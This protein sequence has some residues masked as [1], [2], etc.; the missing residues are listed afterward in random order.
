MVGMRHR[1]GCDD[2]ELRPAASSRSHV[3]L[4]IEAGSR[5]LRT[6]RAASRARLCSRSSVKSRCARGCPLTALTARARTI[7]SRWRSLY[8]S[9]SPGRSACSWT[10]PPRRC[11]TPGA[12][13]Q[14][15]FFK[16]IAS[17]DRGHGGPIP[18]RAVPDRPGTSMP[19]GSS[20]ASAAGS[21]NATAMTATNAHRQARGAMDAGA[22]LLE[23]PAAAL[24]QADAQHQLPDRRGR[25]PADRHALRH[26]GERPRHAAGGAARRQSGESAPIVAAMKTSARARGRGR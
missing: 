13:R 19:R 22:L 20:R 1:I 26:R 21:C 4:V 23:P 25:R 17:D 7:S 10:R 11:S 5:A 9:I 16:A 14:K 3:P 6:A 15:G 8:A 24:R 18:T 2:T 12:G